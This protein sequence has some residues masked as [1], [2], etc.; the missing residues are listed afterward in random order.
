MGLV[1]LVAV[2]IFSAVCCFQLLR[3]ASGSRILG[4]PGSHGE[5]KR[6]NQDFFIFTENLVVRSP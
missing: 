3:P 2:F 5:V 4:F 6:L 1:M